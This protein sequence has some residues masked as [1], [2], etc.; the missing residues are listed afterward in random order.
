MI[1]VLLV[2]MLLLLRTG[3]PWRSRPLKP[4]NSLARCAF[5][6][7][8]SLAIARRPSCGLLALLVHISYLFGMVSKL[9][10]TGRSKRLTPSCMHVTTSYY[11]ETLYNDMGSGWISPDCMTRTHRQQGSTRRFSYRF[12]SYLKRR[13]RKRSFSYRCDL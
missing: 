2:L 12:G 8:F 13:R 5:L 11:L 4:V 7:R 9:H 1:R 3:S 6:N 10:S